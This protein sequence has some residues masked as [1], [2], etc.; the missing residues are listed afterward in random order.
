MV[1]I[2]C[3]SSSRQI[4]FARKVF[5]VVLE[6]PQSSS[7]PLDEC[8]R[9]PGDLSGENAGEISPKMLNTSSGEK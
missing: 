4:Y 9:I 2:C 1:L 8:L 5:E 6:V 7:I 3:G